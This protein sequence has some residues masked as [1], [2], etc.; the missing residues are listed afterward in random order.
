[1]KTLWSPWRSQYIDTFSDEC[2]KAD[3][4][5]FICRAV[6]NIDDDKTGLVV[7]RYEKVIVLMNKYPYNSGHLLVAPNRHTGDILELTTDE[8]CAINLACQKS[9][10]I[11]TKLYHPN[12]FNIG[13]N[14]GECAGAGLPGHLHY[15]VLP[16][17][18]GDTSFVSTI[19][20]TKVI[21]F[22]METMFNLIHNAFN[23]K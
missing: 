7:A 11:L 13:A 21:S 2:S 9:V 1:M 8:L 22:D 3:E 12:G 4:N 16:R 15:H 19:S 5:C 14:L 17:W 10:E 20:D 6:E 18:V 23:S